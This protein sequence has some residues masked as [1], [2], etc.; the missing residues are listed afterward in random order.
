MT[1]HV[2]HDGPWHE[3]AGHDDTRHEGNLQCK[4]HHVTAA[5]GTGAQGEH[6][7][8]TLLL[9]LRPMI[10]YVLCFQYKVGSDCLRQW[11]H[12]AKSER[13]RQCLGPLYS[14]VIPACGL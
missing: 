10:L 13:V 5:H 1:K 3:G 6:D 2:A 7:F 4:T 9:L 8:S 14:T 11:K 12:G